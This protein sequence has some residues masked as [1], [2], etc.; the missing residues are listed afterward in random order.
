MNFT[1]ALSSNS[2]LLSSSLSF[3]S[4]LQPLGYTSSTLPNLT[5]NQQDPILLAHSPSN[6]PISVNGLVVK[7][8]VAISNVGEP[9]VRFPVHADSRD[10]FVFL[11]AF[12]SKRNWFSGKILRC[13]PSS[14]G[15]PWVRFPDYALRFLFLLLVFGALC[16]DDGYGV[17]MDFGG[18]AWFSSWW[19]L[20]YALVRVYCKC[21][22]KYDIIFSIFVII[23]PGYIPC[24]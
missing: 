9:W 12:L 24:L 16:V 1:Q 23:C 17:V 2:F 8:S 21:W 22:S 15:E 13:H 7:F 19:Q 5:S 18:A 14:V 11:G 20:L 3:K 6:H 10:G 4:H